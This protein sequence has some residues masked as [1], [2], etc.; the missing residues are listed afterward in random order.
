M[1]WKLQ[2]TNFLSLQYRNYTNL[3]LNFLKYQHT[4]KTFFFKFIKNTDEQQQI[5]VNI[6]VTCNHEIPKDILQNI[7]KK[8]NGFLLVANKKKEDFNENQ[9]KLKLEKNEKEKM[10]KQ[11]DAN[12]KVQML[13]I[14]VLEGKKMELEC[15]KIKKDMEKSRNEKFR[16]V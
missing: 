14:L 9:K 10:R 1:N 13:K 2:K 6:S 8:V 7:E 3:N 4:V 16:P 5:G 11:E 12:K 15:V